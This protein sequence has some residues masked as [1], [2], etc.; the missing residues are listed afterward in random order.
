MTGVKSYLKLIITITDRNTGEIVERIDYGQKPG[1]E[2]YGIS[3]TGDGVGNV[4]GRGNSEMADPSDLEKVL[5][6]LEQVENSQKGPHDREAVERVNDYLRLKRSL[7]DY[8]EETSPNFPK[9]IAGLDDFE[10]ESQIDQIIQWAMSLQKMNTD[11]DFQNQEIIPGGMIRTIFPDFKGTNTMV[12]MHQKSTRTVIASLFGLQKIGIIP[13]IIHSDNSSDKK[14]EGKESQMA[15]FAANGI[16]LILE[17]NGNFE[18]EAELLKDNPNSKRK[19]SLGGGENHPTQTL[20]ELM[21]IMR[22]YD[23]KK[24]AE[25][26]ETTSENP[27]TITF[28]QKIPRH[29]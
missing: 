28:I 11:Y 6:F 22:N 8:F 24:L 3:P 18:E 10:N 26:R 13:H 27:P 7:V 5:Y 4:A 21:A 1:L 15:T 29:L 9:I 19:L 23:C 2:K 20:A 14:G 17:R 16:D 12:Y 25:L